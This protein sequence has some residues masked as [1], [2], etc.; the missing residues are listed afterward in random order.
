L[1]ATSKFERFKCRF[2]YFPL[3]PL[4]IV[5]PS[6]D[7]GTRI[8]A[9]GAGEEEEEKAMA[10]RR[11]NLEQQLKGV[12]AAIRSKR[13]PPQLRD[14]LRR[15]EVWLKDQVKKNVKRKSKKR[16]FFVFG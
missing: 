16:S 2:P 12:K 6:H 5:W 4:W 14:G 10:R 3:S 15:R 9:D 1:W 8:S 11:L 7:P 13:T